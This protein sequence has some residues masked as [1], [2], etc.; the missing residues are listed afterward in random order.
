MTRFDSSQSH[1]YKT[2]E[3]LIDKLTSFAHIEMSTFCF[4]GDQDWRKFCVL[5]VWSFVVH[6][7]DEVSPTC[8]E[9]DQILCFH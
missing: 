1:F 8:A 9:V 4:S 5:S 2:S 3:L 7:K 6:F